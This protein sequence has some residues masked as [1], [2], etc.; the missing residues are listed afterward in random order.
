MAWPKVGEKVAHWELLR[1]AKWAVDLADY[2]AVVTADKWVGW[3]TFWTVDWSAGWL[4][5]SWAASKA[6][7]M[8]ATMDD[9]LAV[10]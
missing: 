3:W 7:R 1:A 9:N 5:G 2:S 10:Q 8:A 4:V 6:C